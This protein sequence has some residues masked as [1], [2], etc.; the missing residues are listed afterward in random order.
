MKK[1]FCF[2]SVLSFSVTGFSQKEIKVEESK[3]HVG[4]TVKI[5]TKIFDTNYEENAKGSPTFLYTTAHNPNTTLPFICR[6]RYFRF[7]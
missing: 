3:D 1:I 2:I 5:C 7:F 6:R 4:D